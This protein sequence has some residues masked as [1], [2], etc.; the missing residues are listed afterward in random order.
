[1]SDTDD[2]RTDE[3]GPAYVAGGASPVT[4]VEH[5]FDVGAM[6]DA[7]GK[8]APR[9]QAPAEA[10]TSLCGSVDSYG[11]FR[12]DAEGEVCKNCERVRDQ[13]ETTDT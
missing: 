8:L 6:R 2:T 5:L 7:G 4:G 10:I 13:R 9:S 1:M 3:G 12:E 11:P